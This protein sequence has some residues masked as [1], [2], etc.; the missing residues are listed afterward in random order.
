VDTLQI[1]SSEQ[2]SSARLTVLTSSLTATWPLPSQSPQHCAA[3]PRAT[4]PNIAA[5]VTVP[6]I[7]LRFIAPPAKVFG[8]SHLILCLCLAA[9]CSLRCRT[10]GSYKR[11]RLKSCGYTVVRNL[12]PAEAGI[13]AS[14]PRLRNDQMDSRLRGNDE[15]RHGA[16][17]TRVPVGSQARAIPRVSLAIAGLAPLDPGW[18]ATTPR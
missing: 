8:C 11:R 4:S 9:A 12:I 13:H 17:R 2:P 6:H 10:V 18:P 16:S 1:P 5:S 14:C 3:T 15:R 7:L